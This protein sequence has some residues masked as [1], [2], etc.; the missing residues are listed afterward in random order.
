MVIDNLTTAC[1]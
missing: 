1:A